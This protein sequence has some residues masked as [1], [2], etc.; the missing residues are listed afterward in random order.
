MSTVSVEGIQVLDTVASDKGVCQIC[1][2]QG[3]HDQYFLNGIS[4]DGKAIVVCQSINAEGGKFCGAVFPASVGP[5][6]IAWQ[7]RQALSDQSQ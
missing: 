3:K 6:E 1:F 4:A 2:G 5:T 7:Y